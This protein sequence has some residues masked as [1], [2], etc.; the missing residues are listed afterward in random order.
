VEVKMCKHPSHFWLHAQTQYRNV[1]IAEKNIVKIWQLENQIKSTVFF[2]GF[3]VAGPYN[4]QIWINP[5]P[6]IFKFPI[7]GLI[8]NH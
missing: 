4:H 6:E 3:L 2:S 5:H 8:H 1:A 7:S